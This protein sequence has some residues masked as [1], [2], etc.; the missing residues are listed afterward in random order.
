MRIRG[1]VE[2]IKF[3]I[4]CF[5][6]LLFWGSGTFSELFS[7]VFIFFKDPMF[8]REVEPTPNMFYKIFNYKNNCKHQQK[9][10]YFFDE[11]LL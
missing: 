7:S 4:F 2:I 8:L 3:P 1:T 9:S 10:I 5:F 6:E 11:K